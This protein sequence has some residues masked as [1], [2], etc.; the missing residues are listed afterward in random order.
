MATPRL[1]RQFGTWPKKAIMMSNCRCDGPPVVQFDERDQKYCGR[2]GAM[3][4]RGEA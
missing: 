1:A 3:L 4:V 2:C